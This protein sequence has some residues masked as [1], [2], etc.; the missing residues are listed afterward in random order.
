MFRAWSLLIY[1]AYL[2]FE[3]FHDRLRTKLRILYG[4]PFEAL[5]VTTKRQLNALGFFVDQNCFY[6]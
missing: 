4:L 1:F 3:L 2:Q 6:Q 5:K